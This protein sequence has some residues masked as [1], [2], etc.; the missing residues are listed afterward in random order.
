MFDTILFDGIIAKVKLNKK[1]KIIATVGPATSTQ[2]KLEK[3]IRLGVDVF[4]FNLKH[5]EIDWHEDMI[6][7]AQAAADKVKKPIGILIDLQGPEIRIKT[8]EGRRIKVARGK[9]FSISGDEPT[10]DNEIQVSHKE[11][12]KEL[13][14]KDAVLI[15]DGLLKFRVIKRQNGTATLKAVNSY[16]VANNKTMNFPGKHINIPSLVEKD[17]MMM[18]LAVR[19]K[20]DF[21]AL[22]F[23][24]DREDI[25]ILKK[26]MAKR[27]INAQ[28]VAKIENQPAL[29]NLEA[30]IDE[31]DAVM[32]A[33]GDLGVEVPI[34][35]IAYW[36]KKIIAMCRVF[37]K[38]VI[39]ATQMLKS[40]TANPFPTRAEATDVANAVFD[41]TDALMLSEE[42]AMGDYPTQAVAH[43]AGIAEFSE[44]KDMTSSL[45]V[46][47]KNATEAIVES[48]YRILENAKK[49]HISSLVV[50][51]ETGYTAKALSSLRPSLP[52]IA[53][54]NSQKTAETM[55]L[56][57]GVVPIVVKFPKGEVDVQNL[58]LDELVDAKL[59]KKGTNILVTHGV[60]WNQAGATNMV[61]VLKV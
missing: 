57:Y 25:V 38:P 42:T 41:G 59:I 10:K 52:I 5:N 8:F 7:L 17:L 13:N 58:P 33:R 4:R 24:R 40:M 29:D 34:K 18:E 14:V 55:A 37:N 60:R 45:N 51:T 15:D 22:S 3:L 9:I 2:A 26:E 12:L 23:V 28:V 6:D 56:S 35:E 54:T 27:N 32:I 39:V 53:V 20:V 30:I 50:L 16:Y 61:G 44:S 48:A 47:V 49:A 19:K 36:Q 46:K 1:T 31:S 21:I 11:V 43:M